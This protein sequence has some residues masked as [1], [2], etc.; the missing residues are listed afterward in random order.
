MLT[1]KNKMRAWMD[2]E[3]RMAQQLKNFAA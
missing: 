1:G 3:Q 2:G